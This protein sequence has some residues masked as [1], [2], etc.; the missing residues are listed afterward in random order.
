M[1]RH[2]GILAVGCAMGLGL[3]GCETLDTAGIGSSMLNLIGAGDGAGSELALSTI[4]DGLKE[5]LEVGTQ[6]TV[7]QVSAKGGYSESSTIRI[8]MPERLEA[9]ASALRKLGLGSSVDTFEERMNQAAEMAASEAVPVFADAIMSM[10]FDDAREILNGGD[11]AA[12]DYFRDATSASLKKRYSP[13]VTEQ[14]EKV[15]AVSLYKDL[16]GRYND[17]PL[18]PLIDYSIEDYVTEQALDGLFTVLA[19]EEEKI[20]E[21]PAARTTELLK[22]VFGRD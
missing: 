6:N 18:V 8:P 22:T 1:K 19:R 5:A 4:V 7:D 13:I 16:V 15:Q 20:R 11:T 9:M 21:N 14:M 2:I 3:S 12:T 10:S 17:I